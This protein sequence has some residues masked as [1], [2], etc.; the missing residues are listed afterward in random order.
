MIFHEEKHS[1]HEPPTTEF[2][3]FLDVGNTNRKEEK[4]VDNRDYSML[5]LDSDQGRVFMDPIDKKLEELELE[6]IEEEK[7]SR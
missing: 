5:K 4:I 1:S 7:P 6:A 2:N 3:D